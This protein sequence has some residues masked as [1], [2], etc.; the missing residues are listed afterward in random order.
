MNE[1]KYKRTYLKL[2]ERRFLVLLDNMVNV[3]RGVQPLASNEKAPMV[4]IWEVLENRGILDTENRKY[5]KTA[6]T[7]LKKFVYSYI[8]N[9]DNEEKIEMSK[10]KKSRSFIFADSVEYEHLMRAIKESRKCLKIPYEMFDVIL[11]D[12]IS[13]N[14]VGCDCDR[15]ECKLY[16]LLQEV[17][18]FEVEDGEKPNCPYAADLYVSEE[19]KKSVDE[20]K[21]AIK[22]RKN[23]AKATGNDK[24]EKAR[25]KNTVN[26]RHPK[27]NNHN[28]KKKKK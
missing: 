7:N 18:A 14:C 28:N 20:I 9:F 2:D 19:E 3:M 10:R 8:E 27:K 22:E 13:L 11:E 6:F 16:D 17:S 12:V 26:N 25:K 1:Y 21:A 15:K 5:L 24:Y 23:V 4:P